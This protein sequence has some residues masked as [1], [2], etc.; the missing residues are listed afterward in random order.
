LLSMFLVCLDQTVVATAL[1]QIVSVFDALDLA[2]WVSAGYFLTMAGLMLV[3]GQLLDAFPIKTVFL[4]CIV[5]FDIG[6]VI[7]GAA[8]S[9]NVLIFGRVV[10]GCGAAG[11]FTR[12]E[13]RPMLLAAFGAFVAASSIVGPIIGGAF[14][15]HVSWRWCFYINLPVYSMGGFPVI[16]QCTLAHPRLFFLCDST[17]DWIGSVLCLGFWT[18]LILALTW[19]GGVKPWN[20][21]AVIAPLCI[22]A[23]VLIL[24]VPW[25]AYKKN[26]ALVPPRIFYRRTQIAA[27][28]AGF[29]ILSAL[30]VSTYYL[31]LWYQINAKTSTQSGIRILPLMLSYVVA[32]GISAGI[33]TKT[34]RFWHFMIGFPLLSAAGSALLFTVTSTTSAARL[35][36]YQIL[37]GRYTGGSY[38][39]TYIAIQAEWAESPEDTTKASAILTF[40]ANFGEFIALSIAGSIF[41]NHLGTDLSHVPGLAPEIVAVLKESVSAI[42]SIPEP[43]Q[44][45]VRDA[46]TRALRPVFMI[47]VVSSA[48]GSICALYA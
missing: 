44:S 6:S 32:A 19:G 8:P 28:F 33:T 1:P 38:Q 27:C 37:L 14:T 17:L 40:I 21:G 39:C 42:S 11:W 29:L 13:Q 12:P 48:L 35:M 43:L 10:A 23:V 4:V 16:L 41:N 25:E 9:M 34:G 18:C 26:L 31:P 5:L 30:I 15:D 22:A 7:C 46:A 2:T 47:G 3:A 20:S 45:E 36:G 24:F